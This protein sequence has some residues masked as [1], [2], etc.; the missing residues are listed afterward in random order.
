MIRKA[1]VFMFLATTVAMAKS[2]EDVR[3]ELPTPSNLQAVVLKKTLSISWQWRAP[4]ELP[5]FKEFG[6]EIKR[7]D[8]K[9]FRAAATPWTDA[10]LFPGAYTYRVRAR[11]LTMEKGKPVSYIS[12]WSEPVG[13]VIQSACP[14]VPDIE[15]AVEP[16]QKSYSSVT[17]MRFHLRGRASVN[18]GCRLGSVTYRLDTGTGI[19]HSGP[20]PVDAQGHFDAFVNAFGPEDEVP[21]GTLSFSITASAE[22]EAG[23]VTSSAYAIDVEL[24][25]PFA[26]HPVNRGE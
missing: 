3:N 18:T 13:G 17:S 4:E 15:L 6:Y 5:V 8:G 25:N 16:T 23:P 21:S 1:F 9:M 10:D 24:E 20:L 11:G 12:D 2:H 14:K 7:Q 22:D 19:F 26:P